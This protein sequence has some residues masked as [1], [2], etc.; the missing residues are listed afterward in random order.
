MYT[1]KEFVLCLFFYRAWWAPVHG[2]AVRNDWATV[3]QLNFYLYILP[4]I[5]METLKY[6]TAILHLS[7]FLF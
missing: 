6:L 1:C 7:L 5:K 3:N 4:S 2:V